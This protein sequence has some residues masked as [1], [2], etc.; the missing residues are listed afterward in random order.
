MVG[1]T[2]DI[3]DLIVPDRIGDFIAK[4]WV[5][6]NVLRQSRVN[7]WTEQRAHVFATDTTHTSNA[8]LPW[9]N[10]TTIP[11]LCQIR[12]NLFANY[13]ASMFP[14]GQKKWLVWEADNESDQEQS[15]TDAIES[16]MTWVVEQS[17]VKGEI[18]KLVMDYID[19]GNAFAMPIWVDERVTLEDGSIQTGYVGPLARRISPLDIV[20]NPTA[21]SFR[22]TP[23]IIRTLVSLGELKDILEK[24]GVSDDKRE[25]AQ[26]LWTYLKDIRDKVLNHGGEVLAKDRQYQ[27]DGFTSFQSYMRDDVVEVLTFYGDLYDHGEEKFLK[28]HI[29]TVVDRHKVI[30]TRPNP[31]LF[32]YA[33]IYHVGWRIRQDNLWAMGPLDNLVGMQYR[34]DHLEN[35][36]ADIYD[37]T[38]YPVTMIT[39]YVED[40]EWAPLER[41]YAGD[42]GKVEL[43]SPDVNALQANFEIAG[44]EAKMEEM[45]GAPKEALGFRTPGEKT[46]FEVQ[47]LE[48]AATR[49]FQNKTAYFEE[50]QTENLMNGMLEE[51]RRNLT[52]ET[53][54]VFDDEFKLSVF[55]NLTVDDIT[56]SG[57]LRP[58]AAQ[59]FAERANKIQNLNTFYSSALGSDPDIRMHLSGI[60]LAG[61]VED[62]LELEGDEIVQPYVRI[63]EQA[64]AQRQ[65]TAQQEQIAEEVETPS[66]LFADDFDDEVFNEEAANAEAAE[67][68]VIP[69]DLADEA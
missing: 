16:Y 11:K 62:L 5:E 60:K 66:G 42:D 50:Q 55:Q 31:S 27:I 13:M 58:R 43:I 53:I 23:K 10:K 18:Q 52:S 15:K 36:K 56:G 8:K 48:N 29:I 21:P 9:N 40:F 17:Q 32:G 44:L 51:A 37:L 54:R 39:G 67:E 25:E 35:L 1:K 69:E 65:A 45:A 22:E 41:I 38:A 63:G 47:R 2:L 14:V 6:W 49:I 68:A 34:I 26:A 59:H 12:D 19:Y 28:N 4:K 64:D 33:P 61:V 24:Q 57:R 7:E 3:T 30:S 20:F 46:A